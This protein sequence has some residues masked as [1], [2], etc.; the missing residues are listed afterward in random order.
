LMVG[1][2]SILIGIVSVIVGIVAYL[3]SQGAT[4]SAVADLYLG[5]ATTIGESFRKVRGRLLTLFFVAVLNLLVMLGGFALFIFP[6]FY[7]V[8]RLLVAVPAAVVENL[9]PRRSLDRSFHLTR[10]NAGRA[11]VVLLLYFALALAASALFTWPPTIAIAA[12]RNNPS[13]ARF[14]TAIME[15]SNS[16]GAVLVAPVLT[17]AISVF[18]FDLRV[19]KEAFDLQMMLEPGGAPSA[20]SVGSAPGMLS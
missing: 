8:C 14:W 20:A 19:R 11:F 10:K 13:L 12:S 3:L 16:V 6:G 9:G 5:H 15:I 17:I 7:M 4:V 1:P 18:Y 2:T